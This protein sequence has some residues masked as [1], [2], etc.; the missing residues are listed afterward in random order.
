MLGLLRTTLWSKSVS[1][2]QGAPWMS[3]TPHPQRE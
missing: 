1:I 3:R 2:R